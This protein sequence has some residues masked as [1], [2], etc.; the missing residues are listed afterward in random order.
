MPWCFNVISITDAI[1]QE[2]YPSYFK[3]FEASFVRK[4]FVTK[5]TK[6]LTAKM[7]NLSQKFEKLPTKW[8]VDIRTKKYPLSNDAVFLLM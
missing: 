1:Q 3:D 5:L 7:S 6:V 2:K 8:A 4:S